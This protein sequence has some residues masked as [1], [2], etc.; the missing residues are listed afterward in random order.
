MDLAELVEAAAAGETDPWDA[1]VDRFGRLVWSIARAHGLDNA[2]AADVSQTT[3]MRLAEH[4]GNLRDP[5]R[6]ASWLATTARREAVRVSHMGSRQVLVDPWA[7]FEVDSGGAD[8]ATALMDRERDL[9]VQ[10]ALA[11]LPL[12]CQDLLL[13]LVGDPPMSYAE[14]SE[15]LGMPI[16]SIGPSRARCLDEL[17]QMIAKVES[18]RVLPP[19]LK[20]RSPT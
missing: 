2:D 4:I 10:Q 8:P 11:L 20:E 12:R 7:E 9:V 3:W 15:R 1:L 17:R 5:E 6:L 18:G 19:A 16:G 14:I 13:A